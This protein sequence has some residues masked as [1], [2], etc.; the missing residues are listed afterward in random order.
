MQL[1]EMRFQL[2][3][4]HIVGSRNRRIKLYGL[5]SPKSTLLVFFILFFI[6]R[7]TLL[8]GYAQEMYTESCLSRGF[9]CMLN[10]CVCWLLMGPHEHAYEVPVSSLSL[11]AGMG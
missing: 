1:N 3:R 10:A 6:P 7:H 2:D 11:S 9:A 5:S 8:D 4:W